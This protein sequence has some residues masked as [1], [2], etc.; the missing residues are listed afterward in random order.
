MDYSAVEVN[1][2]N[3]LFLDRVVFLVTVVGI[4]IVAI[5][6]IVAVVAIT[7]AA[8]AIA[9]IAIA[10]IAAIAAVAIVVAVFTLRH[11]DTIE[12]DAGVEELAVVG[13]GIE[14][15]D[16]ALRSIVGTADIAVDIGI[17][18]YLEGIGNKTDRSGIEDDIVV[19]ST[20]DIHDLTEIVAGQQL[21]GVGRSRSGKKEVE[22]V[23][24]T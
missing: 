24:D 10:A 1:C 18:G 21:G 17:A 14:E 16:I 15:A 4:G 23:V 11:I 20:E 5:T 8:I 3:H 12:H 6:A 2:D 7:I 13:Q 19:I 22:V 9:T